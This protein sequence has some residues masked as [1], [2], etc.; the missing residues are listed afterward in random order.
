MHTFLSASTC[1]LLQSLTN[2]DIIWVKRHLYESIQECICLCPHMLQNECLPWVLKAFV[3]G[4]VFYHSEGGT[5][6]DA[7]TQDNV[8]ERR[9]QTPSSA[10]FLS[11]LFLA[12]LWRCGCTLHRTANKI[13][14]WG[15]PHPSGSLCVFGTDLVIKKKKKKKLEENFWNWRWCER[16]SGNERICQL[17]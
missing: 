15:G 14:L 7:G 17:P 9:G 13:R 16:K 8:R 2:E 6:A 11:H 3:W 5:A 12:A 1:F 4:T 10:H